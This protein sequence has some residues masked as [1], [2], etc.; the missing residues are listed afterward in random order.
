MEPS[1][2]A[3]GPQPTA[4]RSFLKGEDVFPIRIRVLA[5]RWCE[6]HQIL[7]WRR[8]YDRLEGCARLFVIRRKP[9]T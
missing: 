6:V 2:G 1:H 7:F 5:P 8:S 3:Q 4:L 9:E